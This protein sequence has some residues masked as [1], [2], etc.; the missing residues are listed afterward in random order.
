MPLFLVGFSFYNGGLMVEL[1]MLM[2]KGDIFSIKL[3][4]LFFYFLFSLFSFYLFIF[5][6][7]HTARRILVP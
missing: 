4:T 1:R 5:W 6:P 7:H 3:S 2:A